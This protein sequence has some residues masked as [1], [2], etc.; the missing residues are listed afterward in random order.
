M[1]IL[2]V[3][4]DA[5]F[6]EITARLLRRGGHVVAAASRAA[7]GLKLLRDAA[8]RGTPFQV[9]LSDW[10]MPEMTGPQFCQA[11]RAEFGREVYVI[12]LTG[13][14]ESVRTDG[15]HAGADDF[16][17]KPFDSTDL[18]GSLRAAELILAPKAQ[19]NQAHR[20]AV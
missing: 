4:D 12:L 3:D 15:L 6:L 7:E 1:R 11:V 10:Q 2:L 17:A 8:A 18:Q 5:I 20:R 13:L 19:Q 14:G 16:L 9:I